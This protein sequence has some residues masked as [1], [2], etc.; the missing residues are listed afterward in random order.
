M[1]LTLFLV[2]FL[3]VSIE[4]IEGLTIVL[5]AGYGQS[6]R[7]AILG[8]LSALGLLVITTLV[9]FPL[10]NRIPLTPF[11]IIVGA[12]M[13]YYGVTWL[14]KGILRA[15]HL[16][17]KHNETAIFEAQLQNELPPFRVAFMGVFM[18][19]LE[20]VLIVAALAVTNPLA[21]FGAAILSILTVTAVGVAVRGPLNRVPENAMKLFVGVMLTGIGMF[22][23][24]EA[25]ITWPGGDV[26]LFGI[27]ALVAAFTYIAVRVLTP[28]YKPE[29]QYG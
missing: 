23:F 22:W 9:A 5:A 16:K 29:Q 28:H 13:L 3:A 7:K 1:T 19:G 11:R 10:L 17:A 4:S 25:F 24:G 21:G 6:W 2:I 20:I 14:R 8:A 27:Y 15:A 18:E 26:A 12:V